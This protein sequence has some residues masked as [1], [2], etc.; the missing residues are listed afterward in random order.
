L[1][2][3]LP[4]PAEPRAD[5]PAS[6]ETGLSAAVA[7]PTWHVRSF[8]AW[9][10]VLLLGAAALLAIGLARWITSP[11]RTD[12]EQEALATARQVER[13]LQADVGALEGWLD[14]WSHAP[15]V[16]AL[17]ET[18]EG[19]APDTPV[20]DAAH[21][22]VDVDW[23]LVAD[24]SG[25]LRFRR[26]ADAV[27]GAERRISP[28]ML[29]AFQ[30]VPGMLKSSPEH[31]AG[32]RACVLVEGLPL[33]MVA[34]P[35][36]GDAAGSG[37]M[38]LAA[39]WLNDARLARLRTLSQVAFSLRV[40]RPEADALGAGPRPAL[41][42][43]G[44]AGRPVGIVVPPP[45]ASQAVRMERMLL[46]VFLT[47][48]V[49]VG[50]L[51][52]R[53]ELRE[54]RSESVQRQMERLTLAVVE[55]SEQG[56]LLLDPRTRT[57]VQSNAAARLLVC[58]QPNAGWEDWTE[59]LVGRGFPWDDVLA[60]PL[61]VEREIHRTG[62][63][64]Q[65]RD[66]EVRC[67]RVALVGQSLVL[68]SVRD[69]SD[70]KRAEAEMRHQAY[71][72]PLTHLPNRLLFHEHVGAA[73][74]RAEREAET[75]GVLVID[76]D[77]F[78]VVNDTLGHDV[79][80]QLLV[81]VGQRLIG[82]VRAGDIVA[83]QGGDEFMILTPHLVPPET[84]HT[85]AERVL[86]SL[87][88]PFRLDGRDLHVTASVGIALFPADGV[89]PSTLYR[90]ADMA[91]YHAKHTDRGSWQLHDSEMNDRTSDLLELKAELAAALEKEE[92]ELH[93]QPIVE[94]VSGRIAALEA[95]VRWNHPTRGF[96][97]PS[98]FLPMAEETGLIVQLG[99]WV[100][101]RVCRQQVEWRAAGL[102][103]VRLAVNLSARQLFVPELVESL[104]AILTETGACAGEIEIEVT[105]S[106][107]IRNARVAQD[108]LLRLKQLGFS[109]A[110][111]DFGTGYSALVYLRQ[112]PFDRLKIDRAFLH[113]LDESAGNRSIV[114]AIVALAHSLGLEVVA[115]GVEEPRHVDLLRNFGCDLLQ[116]YGLARPAPAAE[117]R[118]LIA[119]GVL[120]CQPVAAALPDEADARE[121]VAA[122]GILE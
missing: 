30:A 43:A 26:H 111:D 25:M 69:V 112:F 71:H 75:V 80:D 29:S 98:R 14:T 22:A 68:V 31:P 48:V 64:A 81:M 44:F 108:V 4:R 8:P 84:A 82:A 13:A 96:L 7:R 73:L 72:D 52:F 113:D 46:L 17:L 56:V 88:D 41:W 107:A 117:A 60:G 15:E 102:L 94:A 27:T 39:R 116:G 40:V 118:L 97:A 35:L 3:S 18:G 95:L 51:R 114:S 65:V 103:P 49:L 66:L 119:A 11:L 83:R 32:G 100:F 59:P 37:G 120:T 121:R 2:R 36:S 16:K 74:A 19:A 1:P 70:R 21:R 10:T 93:Y 85:V 50:I 61:A 106:V 105:E 34:R 90:N 57:V 86:S 9:P 42:I 12:E 110:L 23:L 122:A 55:Q 20:A 87:R 109:I 67:S 63:D 28:A 33:L 76:L 45:V 58:I 54:V 89:D 53:H 99:D 104:R 79:G 24:R 77:D 115:E 78:K 62:R 5:E 92:L 101:R 47:A 91:M 6:I 38:A